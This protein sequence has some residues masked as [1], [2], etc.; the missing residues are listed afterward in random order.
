MQ[1]IIFFREIC[2]KT[3]DSCFT[4]CPVIDSC[5]VDYSICKPDS[6]VLRYEWDFGDG[7]KVKIGAEVTHTYLWS[8]TYI[9]CATAIFDNEQSCTTCMTIEIEADCAECDDQNILNLIANRCDTLDNYLIQFSIDIDKGFEP[10]N[11]N[12]FYM[13]SEVAGI[14]VNSYIIEEV[15]EN[16]DRI[17]ISAY[18]TPNPNHDLDNVPVSGRITLCGPDDQFICH[19]FELTGH[20]CESCLDLDIEAFA[21]CDSMANGELY[22]SGTVEIDLDIPNDYNFCGATSSESGFE[23]DVRETVPGSILNFDYTIRRTQSGAFNTQVLLCFEPDVIGPE[24]CINLNIT[25]SLPCSVDSCV[26]I[27]GDSLLNLM[28][29]A[30]AGSITEFEF[31]F[32]LPLGLYLCDSTTIS[33]ED[34]DGIS[35]VSTNGN[36]RATILIEMPMMFNMFRTYYM[37]LEVCN[38]KGE[39]I[40]I[41]VPVMLMCGSDSKMIMSLN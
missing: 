41:D 11:E 25:V 22:Y 31:D 30:M 38:H 16:T 21:S 36:Q 1:T 14:S 9:V 4:I 2:V 7:S 18:V 34:A 29:S 13:D 15:D 8:G 10:C 5:F 17:H 28:C 24:I 20:T 26:Q 6:T 39:L 40:C 12:R 32:D 27:F 33:M 35:I 3:C 23:G 19:L 37:Q